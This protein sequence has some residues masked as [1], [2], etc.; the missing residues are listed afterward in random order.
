[1][2]AFNFQCPGC[3]TVLKSADPLE[4]GKKIK[5]PKCA[6]VFQLA[7][8][9]PAETAVQEREPGEGSRAR[10][11][12]ENDFDD[13]PPRSR[14]RYEEDEEEDDYEEVRPRKKK[15]RKKAASSPVVLWLVL[16][17]VGLLVLVGVGITVVWILGGTT[18]S[19]LVGRWTLDNPAAP[20]ALTYEFRGDGTFTLSTNMFVNFQLSG[21]YSVSG[22]TLT[23]VPNN[24]NNP[25]LNFPG[26]QPQL[27][28]IQM[29]IESVSATQ[30]VL[31]GAGQ[32]G[33]P[34]RTVFTRAP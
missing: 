8:A 19:R 22:D 16:G 9:P 5:C 6:T 21:T 32:F 20:G 23:L 30:L 31:S 33:Q 14:R 4:P 13:E 10:R 24:M 29:R 3:Q 12:R 15:R 1:M 17:G 18:Q 7:A 28:Q 2:P 11:R 34:Q 25:G 27:G 26:A